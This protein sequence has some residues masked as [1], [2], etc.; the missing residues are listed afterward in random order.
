MTSFSSEHTDADEQDTS[1]GTPPGI[2]SPLASLMPGGTFDLDPAGR[3]EWER[4]GAGAAEQYCD[5]V[6]TEGSDPDGLEA[7]WE[8]HVFG[9]PP[10]GRWENPEWA[11][12]VRRELREG[13]P[14]S[15]TM[16]IPASMSADWMHDTYLDFDL[17][18]FPDSRLK[19]VN[20][21]NFAP[22]GFDS[23]IAATGDLPDGYE[24]TLRAGLSLDGK[25]VRCEV[26][27]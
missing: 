27:R 5:T 9:N 26:R 4:D 16:L 20:P 6:L 3:A 15:V 8:G 12:K 17:V 13:N 7:S 14:D 2:V 21:D 19:F 1:H 11:G 25:A 23:M 10:Y 18:A 22:A 24:E